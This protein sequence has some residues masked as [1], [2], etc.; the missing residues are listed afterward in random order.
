MTNGEALVVRGAMKP[1]STLTKP[2]RS[3]DTA[4][5]GAGAGACASA[6]T[7]PW[8]PP[9][10]S[11]ARR[12]SR[13][14]SPRATARSSAATTSTTSVAALEAY[15]ER[16]EWRAEPRSRRRAASRSTRLRRLHGGR[17]VAAPARARGWAS[18]AVDTDELIEDELGEPIASSSSARRG[19][20]PRARGAA[21]R[22]SC[23]TAAAARRARRRR[24]SRERVREALA[25]P[26]HRL[27][28]VEPSEVAGSAHR[29]RD[30]PLARD[31]DE[32]R[33]ARRAR[34]ALRG[35]RRAVAARRRRRRRARAA[36]PGCG[37][38]PLPEAA[39]DLG[40]ERLRRLPGVSSAPG[41]LDRSAPG[42]PDAARSSRSPTP[43]RSRGRPARCSPVDGRR[44]EVE[45]RRAGEDPRRGRAA[46]CA[47]SPSAGVRRDDASSPSAAGSSATSP[48]SAPPSTSGG[49]RSSRCRPRS[50]PRSTPPTAARPASTCPRRR[51]TSAPTTSRPRC[52]PTR[53]RSRP[54]PP[55]S[56]PPASPRS[57]RRR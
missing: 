29:R 32:F 13:W 22:S 8:S 54:C 16:I 26:R 36:L 9:P 5:Q 39:A 53:R 57:S 55:R 44:I 19:R 41:L 45:P 23:S 1:I 3:V 4:D 46:C 21:G 42:R 28:R 2:L 30:R 25:R 38:L 48:A 37:A 47:S 40:R 7:R 52:S 43:R 18:T 20:V 6:P 10:G 33:R 56:W 35:A 51:T 49:S 12:W 50:S 17:Q 14:S 34:A 15:R 11:S 24:G 31:R 27:V